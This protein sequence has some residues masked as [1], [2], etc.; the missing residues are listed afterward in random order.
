MSQKKLFF[1]FFQENL[2]NWLSICTGSIRFFK[3]VREWERERVVVSAV[4][5][6]VSD[7]TRKTQLR[8]GEKSFVHKCKNENYRKYREQEEKQ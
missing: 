6:D 5:A 7:G 4:D 1:L 8:Y 3:C 2:Q